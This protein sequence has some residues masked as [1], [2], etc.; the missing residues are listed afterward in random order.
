MFY[1]LETSGISS[2][3]QRIMQFGG[4]RTTLD[5]KPIGQPINVLVKL[6]E[7]ILPEPKAILVHGIAPQKTLAEGLSERDFSQ[8]LDKEIFI[9]DTIAVGFNNIR[10]DDE[11]IRHLFWRSF[12]DPYEWHYKDGRSRWDLLD[13][14]R[15]TRAL[16]PKGL[17]WPVDEAGAATNRLELLA[18]ANGFAIKR[19]HDAESDILAT[20]EW[21]R[22]L[23]SAQPKLF[24]WLFNH[25]DKPAV[26]K[27]IHSAKP[28]SQPF[29]YSSGR[30]PSEFE[31]TTVAVVL[32]PHPT[33]S[34]SVLVYD[35]RHHPE[36]FAGLSA[37]DLSSLLYVAYED[38]DKLKPLPVKKL[39]LNRVPAVA[40][41]ATLDSAAQTRIGLSLKTAERHLKALAGIDGWYER[42]A[43]AYDLRDGPPKRLDPEGRL[44]D[45]F[46]N[47]KDKNLV[48]QVRRAKPDKLAD[49]QP[50]FIDE[51]LAPLLLRY[52]ARNL[53][54]TLSQS[55]QT[56]WESW[57]ADKLLN[58]VDNSL[59]LAEFAQQ[60]A[61]TTEYAAN[62]EQK[63]L[64]EEL[65]LYGESIAPAQL[66]DT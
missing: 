58:G 42:V 15:M 41:P 22:R 17:S 34:N 31:K 27:V 32:G 57:R 12:Y 64:L 20:L 1:D 8:L 49:F 44:Y 52:K 9:K 21:A 5:L 46:L 54:M 55:E 45:G 33:D 23:K 26:A 25:R 3:Y 61:K 24:D 39:A 60:L 43:E 51:R 59:T 18:Q 36:E 2:A 47:D 37:K 29:V 7:D 38:R 11:F 50:G 63:F 28:L 48:S 13:L 65:K 10:F 66:F 4:Q 40:P 16:R 6:S 53:A 62:T 30:Y 56:A 35:L 19:A 14:T